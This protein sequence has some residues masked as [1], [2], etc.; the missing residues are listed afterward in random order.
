MAR[1]IT[2]YWLNTGDLATFIK[3]RGSIVMSSLQYGLVEVCPAREPQVTVPMLY[4]EGSRDQIYQW[5]R[6]RAQSLTSESVEAQLFG[7]IRHFELFVRDPE[8]PLQVEVGLALAPQ[9]FLPAFRDREGTPGIVRAVEPPECW[10][11][12]LPL[13][14]VDSPYNGPRPTRFER[15]WVI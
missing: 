7:V 6:D 15:E 12:R 11:I 8:A 5:I 14:D 4:I 2:W 10:D 1:R 9:P 3:P 13:G